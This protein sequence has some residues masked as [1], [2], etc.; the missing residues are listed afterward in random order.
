VIV[1]LILAIAAV[2]LAF[3]SAAGWLAIAQLWR[4]L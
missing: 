3:A 1:N 4:Q 2:E